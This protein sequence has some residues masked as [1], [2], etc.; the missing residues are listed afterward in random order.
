MSSIEIV[1]N[2]DDLLRFWE[3]FSPKEEGEASIV[4][5][6]ARE[7]Y[8]GK[9]FPSGGASQ[10]LRKELV[11]S[12]D[13]RQNFRKIVGMECPSHAFTLR[14]SDITVPKG[15]TVLYSTIN[16]R[17]T[18]KA[19]IET[20][21]QLTQH[22]FDVSQ[23]KTSSFKPSKLDSTFKS[24]VHKFAKEKIFSD[25]DIDSKDPKFLSSVQEILTPIKEAIVMI[26]ETHG[27]FHVI[28][29]KRKVTSLQNKKLFE[30]AK[31]TKFSK[32]N[33]NGNKS[34]DSLF[35]INSDPMVPVPGTF[36]GDFITRIVHI[37]AFFH[38]DKIIPPPSGK[39]DEKEVDDGK[40]DGKEKD[41]EKGDIKDHKE[42]EGGRIN[43]DLKLPEPP[44]PSIKVNASTV[45]KDDTVTKDGRKNETEERSTINLHFGK[46]GKK[47]MSVFQ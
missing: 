6:I 3:L 27:G 24:N 20:N 13:F 26:I 30:F 12:T 10:V 29:E 39:K 25:I 15:S 36:Q 23:G 18:I 14:D 40:K 41:G 33:R 1:S 37:D 34:T 21:S 17:D 9:N 31:T 44:P 28:F 47:F 38:V 7:K 35:S 45:T 11:K 16:P 43:S 2:I 32:A 19:W 46:G 42:N 5:L 4:Q 22:L 8:T